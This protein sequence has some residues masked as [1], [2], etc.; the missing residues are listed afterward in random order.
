METPALQ[1]HPPGA[2]DVHPV[3]TPAR[4]GRPLDAGDILAKSLPPCATDF[5]PPPLPLA[6]PAPSSDDPQAVRDSAPA[7]ARAR[8]ALPRARR[9]M[10]GLLGSWGARSGE[11]AKRT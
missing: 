3:E 2:G 7:G 1:G 5:P 11:R 6:P 4:Q 8:A 10:T 9:D